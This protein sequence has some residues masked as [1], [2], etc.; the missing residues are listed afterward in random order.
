LKLPIE[1]RYRIYEFSLI[2]ATPLYQRTKESIALG[3]GLLRSCRQVY[4]EC[5]NFFYNNN[6]VLHDTGKKFDLFKEKLGNNLQEVTVQWWGSQRRDPAIFKYLTGCPKLKILHL[7][8]TNWVIN[9][10]HQKTQTEYQDDN[11]IRK[12]SR[13]NGFDNLVQIRG[14]RMV[15][16]RH[17]NDNLVEAEVTKEELN[18]FEAFLMGKLTLPLPLKAVL[19]SSWMQKRS[20]NPTC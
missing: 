11:T 16:V 12:F 1:L 3:T 4:E 17:I 18:V 14:L 13:T 20:W 19:V 6:F 5:I 15:T 2:A 9:A 8:T 10:T 7:V